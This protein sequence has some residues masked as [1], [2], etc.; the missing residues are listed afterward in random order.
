M[1]PAPSERVAAGALGSPPCQRI[2]AVLAEVARLASLGTVAELRVEKVE[3]EP[4]AP[5]V[6][7]A[8][9]AYVGPLHI[10]GK[11]FADF[12]EVSALP[13][14]GRLRAPPTPAPQV[15]LASG[16]GRRREGRGGREAAAEFPSRGESKR[17]SPKGVCLP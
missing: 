12:N 1:V 7:V 5:A 15:I 2:Q 16:R 14:L 6:E 10:G 13:W 8:P 17:P 9:E 3:N 11:H 4:P